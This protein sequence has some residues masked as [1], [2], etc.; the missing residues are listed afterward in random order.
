[1]AFQLGLPI[2]IFKEKG[3]LAEGI[4]EK[5]VVGLY[6]PEFSLAKSPSHYFDTEEW[7]Q[8]IGKWEGAVRSVVESKGN[9]PKLY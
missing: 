6:M 5:G 7:K 8:I 1:M 2:L 3:V 4:L 9:P